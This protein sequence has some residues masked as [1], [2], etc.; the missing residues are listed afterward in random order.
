M[1]ERAAVQQRPVARGV[2]WRF[3]LLHCDMFDSLVCSHKAA[4]RGRDELWRGRSLMDV[5]SKAAA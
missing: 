4:L 2:R 1:V 3:S 5:L